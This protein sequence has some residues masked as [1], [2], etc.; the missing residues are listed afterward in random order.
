MYIDKNMFSFRLI[1]ME[2]L[3]ALTSLH[4]KTNK[5][6]KKIFHMAVNL[7]YNF[8]KESMASVDYIIIKVVFKP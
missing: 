8:G 7:P 4:T 3:K 5:T 6:H 1:K 2:R